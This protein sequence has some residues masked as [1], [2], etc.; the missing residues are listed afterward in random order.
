MAYDA[1][2]STEI[3]VKKPVTT[4][5]W[6]KVKGNFEYFLGLIGILSTTD[7]PN[8]FFEVSSSPGSPDSWDVTLYAGG[9]STLDTSAPMAGVQ[10]LKFTHPGGS[11]NGGGYAD[12]EYMPCGVD[13]PVTLSFIIKSSNTTKN[14]VLFR[15]FDKD[16]VYISET[17][18][19]NEVDT[20]S[21][22]TLFKVLGTPPAT[23][24]Y[25][26]IRLVGGFNDT[27]VS[28]SVWF[29]AVTVDISSADDV[30]NGGDELVISNDAS[31]TTTSTSYVLLK[32]I[33]VARSG[34]LRIEFDLN[35]SA[36]FYPL[37]YGQIYIN[38]VA[39]GAERSMS[40]SGGAVTYTEDVGGIR[41]SDAVQIYAKTTAV[42]AA[43]ITNF[44]L[45]S[46][47]N[48]IEKNTVT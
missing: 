44:R 9:S 10:S 1:I 25:Y 46:K 36:G 37:V 15:W 27:D 33:I 32:E 48:F 19:Y 42:D 18:S 11:G 38:G 7:I 20:P 24:K 45:Y 28:G 43:E 8:G 5:L 17:L 16:K 41:A 47:Y 39:V 14:R 26:R 30:Y 29:D 12:S 4:G 21:T 40:G 22:Q 34:R 2:T 3:Q 31:A 13:N 6:Q 23:A 35:T